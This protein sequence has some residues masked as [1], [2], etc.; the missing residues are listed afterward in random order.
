MKTTTKLLSKNKIIALI[1]FFLIGLV[2]GHAQVTQPSTLP[3]YQP[4]K[5]YLKIKSS[6]NERIAYP[7]IQ[8]DSAG[9][10]ASV[11][12]TYSVTNVVAPF[13]IL[14]STAFGKT[15]RVTFSDTTHTANFISALQGLSTVQYAEKVPA[16][17]ATNTPNDPNIPYHLALV[18]ANAA[19]SIHIST[20][21]AIV[22]IVDDAVLSTH[23]DL[24]ANVSSTNRDVAD[25]DNDADPPLTGTSSA[26]PFRF[27]HG[28]HV[29]GIAGG[30]TNN[31]IGIASVGWNNKIMCVKCRNDND[32]TNDM[33]YGMDGVAWAAANGAH[34]INMSWGGAAPSQTDYNVIVNAK[35]QNIVLVAAAGNNA[36]GSAFYPAAY[37]EGLTGQTWEVYNKYLV[38]A[39]AALDAN[40]NVASWGTGSTGGILGSDF[41]A[42]VDISAYGSGILST[43]A[44]SSG[45]VAINNLYGNLDGTSMAAPIV[46]GIAGIMKSYDMT[47]TADQIISCL[48]N[49]AN[50]DIYSIYTH[51]GNMLN[52]LGTGRVDAQAALECISPSC[53]NPIV[54]ISPSSN[55]LCSGS[56]VTL[57]ANSAP[58]YTWSTGAHTQSINVTTAGVYTCSVTYTGGCVATKTINVPAADTHAYIILTENSGTAPN[59]GILCGG[60]GCNVACN[61]GGSYQWAPNWSTGQDLGGISDG[62]NSPY[63]SVVSV[64]VTAVNGCP[65]VTSTASVSIHWN[66]PPTL[67]V[68][69]SPATITNGCPTTITV[70]GAS[71]YIWSP[72]T[73]MDCYTCAS[74][75]FSPTVAQQNYN[76]VGTDVNGC[77]NT[78]GL[79]IFVNTN[80]Y[81]AGS[82]PTSYTVSST[83]TFSPTVGFLSQNLYVNSGNYTINSAD[84]RIE[85]NVHIYVANNATLTID[86]SWLHS[87]GTCGKSMWQGIIVQPGGM[88]NVKNYSIIEDADTTIKTQ[89]QLTGTIS[90]VWNIS[91]SIFNKN[92]V[93]LYVD[94]NGANMSSNSIYN[95]VFTCRNLSSH[96][97]GSSN[98]TTQKGLVAAATP[99]VPGTA[100]P[101][102]TL[103]GTRTNTHIYLNQAANSAG[104]NIGSGSQTNNLFDNGNYG[105]NSGL[106]T[107]TVKNNTFQNF[108]G[109]TAITVGGGSWEVAVPSVIIGNS[110]ST[111]VASEKNYFTNCLQGINIFD[112]QYV[113]INN[114]TFNNETTSATFTTTS[115]T[116]QYAVINTGFAIHSNTL[117]T[118]EQMQFCNNTVNNYATGYYLDFG[119]VYNPT[120][121]AMYFYNNIIGSGGTS[122]LYCNQGIY[123]QQ[124]NTYG[125]N[126]GVPQ[127]MLYVTTNSITNVSTNA[128]SVSAVN[129]ATATTGFVTIEANTELSVKY[130]SAAT[131]TVSP[132]I[133]AVYVGGSSCIKIDNNTKI[134]C[135]SL[136]SYTNTNAQYIAGI[137]ISTSPSSTVNC[138]TVNYV[139]EGFVWEGASPGSQWYKNKVQHSRFGLVLRN[140]G[141]MGDQGSSGHPAGNIWGKWVSTDITDDQTLADHSNPGGTGTS[142]L[143][144]T[145]ATCTSTTTY[146]PCQNTQSS[147]TTYSLTTT[148]IST[149]GSLPCVCIGD[150]GSGRMAYNNSTYADSTLTA[151]DSMLMDLV[152]NI[153]NGDPLPIYDTQTRWALQYYVSSQN[154]NLNAATGYEN[155]K[156]FAAVDGAIS[157]SNYSQAQTLL[158]TINPNNT[159]ENNWQLVDNITIKLQG[160]S[161][162][163]IDVSTLHNVAMQCPQKGG[164]IVYTARALLNNYY[165]NII[166]YV[167]SCYDDNNGDNRVASVNKTVA[168]KPQTVTVYPNPNNGSMTFTYKIKD[169]A[170]LEIMDLNGKLV[171]TYNLPATNYRFEVKSDNLKDGVYF[172]RVTDS[173]NIVVKI[174][175]I[176]VMQ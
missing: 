100:T 31:S 103:A 67:T 152:N 60:D 56:T 157:G 55:V 140:S 171:G 92:G 138:N 45:G 169:D 150:C 83:A 23:E 102:V 129:T 21:N 108:T 136:S 84:V 134:Q 123:M 37:G 28:T 79:T 47:K 65:G 78:D 98:F 61:W 10:L 51:P 141:V 3:L 74:P 135:T 71:T 35:N 86:G 164:N 25:L 40:N 1:F 111:V 99:L 33:P 42:W 142:K 52:S 168:D 93:N 144:S 96:T 132:H 20:G 101:T 54:V 143:Y 44:S 81:C 36:M 88:I 146:L 160:N 133:A 130:N 76:V 2:K 161:L 109:G 63:T 9:T 85:P 39:V 29:A 49:T 104:I 158:N 148:L 5:I 106:S 50:P 22:A 159:L 43:L 27:T 113:F 57:T 68:N 162:D 166:V 16:Y 70:S 58:S 147:G 174:G 95:T 14:D 77:T 117:V 154:A 149:T 110:S 48:L 156:A 118:T 172:Y 72:S 53:A 12:A 75:I 30:V 82:P 131:T 114:N 115:A 26:S 62:N 170:R 125:S 7:T 112:C 165:K 34:V 4:G 69:P 19:S 153:E 116:G 89:A 97:I 73:S 145:A 15:Y 126:S 18:N 128:I 46:S 41:G 94:V 6:S 66:K 124:S 59:D 139:G 91:N 151:K 32:A 107:I 163:S 121:T 13:A 119:K 176:I 17:Y 173:K 64:T 11:F 167:D 155:A 8:N 80:T 87:C 38:V 24:A 175:K 90:P 127:D 137:Y 105:I 122:S 120:S